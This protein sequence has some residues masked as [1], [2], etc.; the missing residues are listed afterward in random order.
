MIIR[1]DA[2]SHILF[3]LKAVR[4]KSGDRL[5]LPDIDCHFFITRLLGSPAH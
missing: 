5:T 2:S 4:P 1:Y 3:A